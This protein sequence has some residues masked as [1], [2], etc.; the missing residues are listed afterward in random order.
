MFLPACAFLGK[1]HMICVLD[2]WEWSIHRQLLRGLHVYS[3]RSA[4]A[5]H[6][7][8][9]ASGCAFLAT[10]TYGCGH[11]SR[12]WISRKGL[13]WVQPYLCLHPWHPALFTSDHAQP[14]LKGPACER[15]EQCLRASPFEADVH[16]GGA[17]SSVLGHVNGV[18]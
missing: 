10:P 13:R 9:R 16:R 14:P 15:C 7:P 6:S 1:I 17:V 3:V 5:A 8:R 2:V 4:P 18:G 11:W 12:K